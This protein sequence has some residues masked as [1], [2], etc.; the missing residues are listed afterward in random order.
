MRGTAVR[1]GANAVG[2]RLDGGCMLPSSGAAGRE[3]PREIGTL[4]HVFSEPHAS[5]E[6]PARSESFTTARLEAFSDGVIAVIITIMV[7]ELKVPHENG[8]RG[9]RAVLP[10]LLVYLLS[11]AFTGIY[12]V[13]HHHLL[14]RTEETDGRILYSN[15]LF[16]FCLSLLPFTTTWV[17][18]KHVDA[19]SAGLYTVCLILTGF[20]FLLLRMAVDR[21]LQNVGRYAEQDRATQRKHI[22]SLGFY[23]VAVAAA[24]YYPV[25]SLLLDGCVTMVWI[26][27]GLGTE[28]RAGRAVGS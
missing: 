24:R 21:T 5:T 25:V 15:L 4:S 16:L 2:A 9:L 26:L 8:A 28:M 7:L 27:P 11:F 6:A 12:W 17:L 14:H 18:E 19:F 3:A 22:L 13:N 23:F 20:S 10:T 1:C